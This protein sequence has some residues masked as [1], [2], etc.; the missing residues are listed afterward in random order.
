M[1]DYVRQKRRREDFLVSAE[2]MMQNYN[3]SIERGTVARDGKSYL[4]NA[5]KFLK[6]AERVGMDTSRQRERYESLLENH[7]SLV[8]KENR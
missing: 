6:M 1:Q 2:R 8:M 4:D 5:E 7:L 3:S